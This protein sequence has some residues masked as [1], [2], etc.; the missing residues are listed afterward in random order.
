MNGTTTIYYPRCMLF[1][2]QYL[3]GRKL[4]RNY[5][6]LLPTKYVVYKSI[7]GREETWTELLQSITH[8][9]CC[10]QIYIWKGGNMNGTTT[11][12]YPRCMLI[13]NLYLEGRKH[14]NESLNLTHNAKW[15]FSR[16]VVM[17]KHYGCPITAFCGNRNCLWWVV[18]QVRTPSPSHE[19]QQLQTF[20]CRQMTDADV[21]FM[22]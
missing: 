7:F 15:S 10:L 22:S 21:R 4:E 17:L 18:K 13:T 12:Y 19:V 9:V 16:S 3:E 11:T 14:D 2:N 20:C 6:N 1:T 5:Y 8:E